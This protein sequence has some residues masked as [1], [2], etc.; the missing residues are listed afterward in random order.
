MSSW[1]NIGMFTY[2]YI[3]HPIRYEPAPKIIVSPDSRQRGFLFAECECLRPLPVTRELTSS[4]DVESR[5]ALVGK[6]A[7]LS[8]GKFFP[9]Y[10]EIIFGTETASRSMPS[11]PTAF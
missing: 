6:D 8:T 7:G 5:A 9:L 3:V 10:D 2:D 4:T 11:C 1:R